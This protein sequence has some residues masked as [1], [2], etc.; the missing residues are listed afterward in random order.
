MSSHLRWWKS[1]R[2]QNHA[3]QRADGITR[4]NRQFPGTTIE[5]RVGRVQI[6]QQQIVIIDLPGFTAWKAPR[7]RKKWRATRCVAASQTCRP[8]AALIVV[9]ATNLERNLFLVSQVLE[10]D[11]PVIVALNMMDMAGREDIR[12]DVEK[13]RSELGCALF[14]LPR[15]PERVLTNSSVNRTPSRRR[16]AGGHHALQTNCAVCGGCPYQARYEWIESISA[17]VMDAAVARRS[18]HTD[19]LD[20]ILT[21]PIAGMVVFTGVMLSLFILIFWPQ[22]SDGPH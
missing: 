19:K 14:R 22:K 12:I 13:L 1:Q 20:K 8:D 9:D 4:Q 11:C 5:R 18:Q 16:D 7:R 15:A 21:H 10:L 3:I 17:K 2:R 6:G